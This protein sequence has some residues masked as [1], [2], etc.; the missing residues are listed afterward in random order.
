MHHIAGDLWSFD[1]L[2]NELQ[3]LYAAETSQVSPQ[4]I[5]DS[6]PKNKP[7]TDFVHWQSEM[8]SGSRGEKLWEY[9]QKQLGGELPVLNLPVDRPRPPVQTYRGET[10][11][12][13][14][15]SQLI[16]GLR[17]LA[18]ASGTSL[19]KILLAAFYVQLY[20]YTNQED[21]LVGSPMAGRWGRFK[22]IE[23][24]VGY[25]VNP[26]VLRASVSGNLTFKEFLAQVSSKVREAQ[27]YQDYP[28]ALL[29]EQL[30]PQ[31]DPSCSPLFQVSFTWQK[32]RWCEPLKNS[33][34]FQEQGLQMEPYLLGHQRGADFD[35]DVMVMEAQ[36]L[37]QACWQYNIDLFDAATISRMAGHFQTLLEGIVANPEQ[38][39]SE[40]PLLTEAERHQL[41]LEWNN[42]QTDFPVRKCIHHLFEEQ[43]QLTPNAVAVEFST[44]QLTYLQLN[45]RANKIA[46]YLQTLG[47]GPE[48]LVGICV[49]RSLEMVVGLLGILKAGGAYVPLD[50]T[51]PKERIAYML[52]DSRLPVLLTQKKLVASLPESKPQ[53]VCLDTEKAAIST[54]STENPVSSVSASNQAYLIYTSGSTGTPKGVLIS[55]SGLLNL[56]FWHQRAFEVTASDRASQLAGTAFDASVWELWPYL[57]AGASIYLVDSEIIL[58]PEKLRDWLVSKDIT[59]TFV[60]TPLAEKLLSVQWPQDGALRIML[61]GG[62]KLHQYPLTSIPFKLVNN[63]G[64]TENTVVTTSGLVV[65]NGTDDASPHIGR[66]ITNTQVYILDNHLQPVPIGVPGELYIGGAGLARGYLNRPELTAERFISNP[67]SDRPSS[68]LY[69]TGD[70]ARYLPDGNIEYL[71]RLDN[72]VKIRGFR[73]E[74]G[75]IEAVLSQHP[76]VQESVVVARDD[77][78][79]DKRLVAYLVLD[80]KSKALPEQVSQWQREQVSEWLTLYE[81]TYSQSQTS[82]KDKMFNTAGWNRSYTGQPIPASEMRERVDSTVARILSVSPNRVLEIG[83]GTGLLLSRIAPTCSQYWGTDYSKAAI[84]QVE[85]LVQAVEGLKHV[86]LL[87]QMADNFEDIPVCGFDTV[88]LNSIVQYFPSVEYLLQVIEGAMGAIGFSGTIFV[89]DV[90]S[91]PLLSV[92][93]SAVRLTRAE[94]SLNI[95]QWQQLVNQSLAAEEELVI[96]PSFFIALTQRYPEIAIV[97]IQPKRGNYRNELSQFRYDVTLHVGTSAPPTKVIPWHNWQQNQ[98]SLAEIHLKLVQ[99]QPEL[100]GVRRVANQRVQQALQ[101][102][103]WLEHPPS[104]VSTVGELRQLLSQQPAGGIDPEEFWELG[105]QVPYTVHL[106]WWEASQDGCY[107]VVFCRTSSKEGSLAA[108]AIAF[109][110]TQTVTH[111]PLTRYTN[112]PLGG[113]LVQKLVPLVREFIQQKLPNYMVPQAF[114]LLDA[115]PLTPNG[116]VDRRALPTPDIATRNLSTGFVAPRTPTEA[117][118]AQIWSEVLGVERIGVNDNFFELGGHSLLAT[119]VIY[120]L[121]ESFQVELPL[122]CLFESPTIAE[123]DKSIS[124]HRLTNSGLIAPAIA[125]V[126]RNADHLPISLNQL[127]FWLLKQFYPDLPIY[128]I[129]LVYRFTG[130]LNLTALS[131]SLGEIMRRHEALRTGL[132]LVDGQVVQKIVPEGVLPFSVVDMREFS[133]S[134]TSRE[135]LVQRLVTEEINQLFDLA[136]APLWRV[137]LLRYD[138]TEHIFIVTMHHSISDGWSVGVFLKEL[139]ALYKA[140]CNG[141]PSPLPN[142][143]LQ[144]ADFAV[145]ERQWLVV[146][147]VKESHLDYW[148]QQLAGAPPV[149]QL[150]TDRKRSPV[151]TYKGASQSLLLPLNLTIALKKYSRQQNVTLFVTLLTA[152]KI[153]LFHYSGQ[154]DIIVG[155]PFANREPVETEAL[156]GCFLNT[157]PIRT[158]VAG[159]PSFPELLSRVRSVVTAGH[160]HQ[161]LPFVKLLEALQPKRVPSYLPLIQVQ[162]NFPFA[163]PT[164]ELSNLT[165]QLVAC[166]NDFPA[167]LDLDVSLFGHTSGSLE[168]YWGYKTD[169]FDGSTIE[170][171]TN[172][173]LAFLESIVTNPDQKL[174][175]FSLL[176]KQ[177]NADR[178]AINLECQ[179]DS[180]TCTASSSSSDTVSFVPP[181]TPTEEAIAAIWCDVLGIEQVGIHDNFFEL[182]GHSQL[183]IQVM[184]RLGNTFQVELPLRFLFEQP[185]VAGLAAALNTLL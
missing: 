92:Y 115:L 20:R 54:E 19:Y 52:S 79:G 59:I 139:T 58:S 123:L 102:G 176:F 33:S 181:R 112:N 77:T 38:L 47:V 125:P 13:K 36:G 85:H 121:R 53:I 101:I 160:D 28:F 131:Q 145:R 16:Q 49:E 81:Q 37:L 70:K 14:L 3:G 122:R 96:D 74:P 109:W 39:V 67:N 103:E 60:P 32:Q 75:E 150:P 87:H 94:D 146:G 9:W 1:L 55:H 80:L 56:I 127:E 161:Q 155:V 182:G 5:K 30:Q 120:R 167:E 98:L 170:R 62:D 69:K 84:Q 61:T 41:I 158:S 27:K 104:A 24:I 163:L 64:P 156:I 63:Y 107:D 7:Y 17:E 119:Q 29:V 110:D 168:F 86:R 65:Y 12:F 42:T 177:G 78:P 51:Y 100:L 83:C 91:L 166:E 141:K 164:L 10:H 66:P 93:H 179:V 173:F 8:L 138:E 142:L 34:H 185:T 124:Q 178:P 149:L 22:G 46:H 152:F 162:F 97:E 153:L 148:K 151:I 82:T 72:Q 174:A 117:K 44:Q 154:S 172:Q 76:F 134:K 45:N 23:G 111:S 6:L 50:P 128:N 114:V 171:M 2:L 116:K 90:R 165:V 95:V 175:D 89:G 159:N 147:Q 48:V 31:R 26:V 130:L 169:L 132:P 126:P 144:P 43:V 21:I 184:Y 108:G 136:Q 68:R 18:L 113:K 73:I 137:K 135:A 133:A 129:P 71:G 118:L 35:L 180:Y 11:I 25:L 183:A 88:I 15:D 143:P 105:Q 4:H 99:E 140:F 40:L 106:S 57:A 157:L